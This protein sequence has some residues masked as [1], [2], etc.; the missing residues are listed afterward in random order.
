MIHTFEVVRA[1]ETPESL[2]KKPN[3]YMLWECKE[4]VDKYTKH[5]KELMTKECS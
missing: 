2:K 4:A 3:G 1:K 5:L